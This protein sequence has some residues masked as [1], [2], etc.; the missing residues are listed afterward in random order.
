M[1]ACI[2]LNGSFFNSNR[3]VRQYAQHAYAPLR[4][5]GR[6]NQDREVT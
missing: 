3:T 1:R 2:G 6:T 4:L 5:D